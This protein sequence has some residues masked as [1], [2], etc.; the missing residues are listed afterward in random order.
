MASNAIDGIKRCNWN[1]D[2]NSI[3]HT[4]NELRPWWN[5]DLGSTRNIKI[6]KTYNREDCCAERLDN[7]EVRIGDDEDVFNNPACPEIYSGA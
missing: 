1:W 7:F 4:D 2:N 6:I 5:A 3:T